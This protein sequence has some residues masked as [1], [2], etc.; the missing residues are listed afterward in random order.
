MREVLAVFGRMA[1]GVAGEGDVGHRVRSD[2]IEELEASACFVFGGVAPEE[3]EDEVGDEEDVH[4]AGSDH[5]AEVFEDEKAEGVSDGAK[6]SSLLEV[7]EDG[8][9]R[10]AEVD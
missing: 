8:V 4:E 5:R 2:Q 9:G 10:D 1:V 7:V 6:S 3:V